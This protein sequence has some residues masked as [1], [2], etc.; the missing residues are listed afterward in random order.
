MQQIGG[1]WR[2]PPWNLG[3]TYVYSSAMSIPEPGTHQ[4]TFRV[5]VIRHRSLRPKK[6]RIAAAISSECVSSAKWPVL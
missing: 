4:Y 6:S 1:T 2:R 3:E 5:G